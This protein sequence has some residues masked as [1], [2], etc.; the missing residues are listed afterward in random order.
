MRTVDASGGGARLLPPSAF[1]LLTLLCLMASSLR[2]LPSSPDLNGITP[3][4]GQRGTEVELQF[5]G[6]RLDDAEQIVTYAPGLDVVKLVSVTNQLVKAQVKIAADCRLGEHHLRV[7]TRS[8][9]SDVQTFYVGPFPTV[10]EKEPNNERSQA[11]PVPWNS[12]VTGILPNEDVDCFLVEARKGQRLSAEVEAMRLGRAA[13]DVRMTVLDTNGAV[14]ADADDSWL[15]LQDPILSLIVPAD[16]RYFVQIREA[17]YGGAPNAH[18]RLHLGTFPRPV[19]V[20]PPG[21]RAGETVAFTF[22]STATG[23]FTNT[24]KLPDAPVDRFGV[25][26]ELEGG[27]APSPNWIRVSAFSNVLEHPPNQDQAHATP[28]G[29]PLPVAFNGILAQP[30]E[31]DWFGFRAEKSQAVELTAYA[32][33]LRSPVDTV[34]DLVDP[35][36]KY[37]TGNDDAGQPD[38]AFKFTPDQSTNYY[39]RVRDH[40]GQGGPDYTYRVEVTPATPSLTLKIP[41][42]AR[43]DTQTRQVITVPRGNSFGTLISA[44]RVNFGGELRLE[45]PALPTGVRLDADPMAAEVEAMPLVFTAAPDAPVGGKLVELSAV[46][47]NAAPRVVGKFRQE[48]GLVPGPNNT[49]YYTTRVDPLLVAVTQEAP[50]RVRIV[51]PKVP[52]VQ[53]GSMRLDVVTERNAGFT[54]PIRINMIWNPPGVSSQ[55]EATIPKGATNVAYQLNAAG[56]A[57]PRTW[58]IAVLASATVNGGPL[59]VASPLAKLTVAPPYVAG[60]LEPLTAN[61]G[62]STKLVCRLEQAKAFAGK[63]TIR[64]QGLP[65]KITTSE[66]QI[67][68]D[69]KEVAFD[70]AIDAQCPHG[71]YRNLFCTVDVPEAGELMAHTIAGGGIVRVV[72]PKKEEPA[73]VAAAPEKKK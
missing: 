56:G 4:G 2:L 46:W 42:V 65:P 66:K 34:L 72:P 8:G 47:T 67:T 41:E 70:L 40:L 30:G 59:Y 45:A 39:V 14:L 33:Q 31:H 7:R 26:A 11:Q 73:K 54:E 17:A 21:G 55:S 51:E 20:Y 16:G 58:R 27:T 57:A 1:P 68:K 69:D 37:V 12:T 50:F 38:S 6:N 52:L 71:S 29:M 13:I 44:R 24:L 28:A 5:H 49:T 18:Y 15:A 43:N 61:P 22:F 35:T 3:V 53:A 64:L 48:V 9:V 19:T 62:Q 63:A 60:K 36:G 32:R 25:F 10:A 23:P